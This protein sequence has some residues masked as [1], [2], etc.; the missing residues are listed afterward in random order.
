MVTKS[1]RQT[2]LNEI[3]NLTPEQ[4][5]AVLTY[6]LN[7]KNQLPEGM[8]GEAMIALAQELNFDSDDLAEIEAAIEEGYE[9]F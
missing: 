6:T 4:Q 9:R 5:Q 1:I 7:L 8:S 2:L 3:D